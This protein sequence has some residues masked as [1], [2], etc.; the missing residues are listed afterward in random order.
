MKHLQDII[1]SCS[2]V[3]VATIIFDIHVS[4]K[5]A[6]RTFNIFLLMIILDLRRQ[7]GP[8]ECQVQSVTLQTL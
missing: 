8:D 5:T 1:S 3:E 7:Q 4:L 6:H 2:T